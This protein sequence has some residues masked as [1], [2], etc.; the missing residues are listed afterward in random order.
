M[1]ETKALAYVYIQALCRR[2]TNI[3]FQLPE[4][5]EKQ[6]EPALLLLGVTLLVA[7]IPDLGPCEHLPPPPYH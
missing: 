5:C 2:R 7:I 6:D 1:T 4:M 3:C